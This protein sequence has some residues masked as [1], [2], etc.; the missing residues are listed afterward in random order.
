AAVYVCATSYRELIPLLKAPSPRV[1]MVA[2]LGIAFGESRTIDSFLMA[3][4]MAVRAA[5]FE[6]LRENADQ[7][8]YLRHAGALA[9]A[10]QV[11]PDQLVEGPGDKSSAVRLAVVVALRR[12]KTP[13]VA[14]FLSDTDPK[15]VAEAARAI[16]DEVISPALPKLAE[17][18]SRPQLPSV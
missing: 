5:I 15:V 11:F 8:A 12:Q 4:G 14:A 17:L 1:R 18:L 6:M 9:L 16:N 2:A 13:G 10:N 3:R 7:D